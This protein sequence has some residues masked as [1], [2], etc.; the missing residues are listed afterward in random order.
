MKKFNEDEVA[1]GDGDGESVKEGESVED[2]V[3]SDAQETN[4]DTLDISDIDISDDVTSDDGEEK[5]LPSVQVDL[6]EIGIGVDLEVGETPVEESKEVLSDTEVDQD[7]PTESEP[8]LEEDTGETDGSDDYSDLD[9]DDIL[10]DI[11]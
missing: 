8:V 2:D 5:T 7:P 4:S 9:L 6:D 11:G 3:V 1:D 10:S